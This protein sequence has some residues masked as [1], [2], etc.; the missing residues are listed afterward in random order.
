MPFAGSSP[1]CWSLPRPCPGSHVCRRARRP[2]RSGQ[3]GGGLRARGRYAATSACRAAIEAGAAVREW[4]NVR[5]AA[6]SGR[7]RERIP[8]GELCSGG[9]SAYRGLDLPGPTG[10]APN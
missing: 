4:D 1:W 5:V 10:R 3:P 6:I 9:L 8:D 2:D 7:D